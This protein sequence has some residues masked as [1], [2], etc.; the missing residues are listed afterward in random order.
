MAHL[1]SI[2]ERKCNCEDFTIR[3]EFHLLRGE[4]PEKQQC[5]HIRAA[6]AH[7]ELVDLLN[8]NGLDVFYG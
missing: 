5:K 6:K 3:I 1:R 8:A 2:S 7:K 4:E